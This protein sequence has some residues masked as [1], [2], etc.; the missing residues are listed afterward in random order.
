ML[1][2]KGLTAGEI[3]SIKTTAGE[4]II[5]KLVEDNDKFVKVSKPLCLT[6][7]KEGIGLVPFMFTIDPD[8]EISI[9]KQTVMVVAPSV[10][11]SADAYLQNTTGIKLA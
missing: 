2:N 3:I 4:E 7:T 6:A 10:K 8:T 1:I 11:H 9:S 5:A